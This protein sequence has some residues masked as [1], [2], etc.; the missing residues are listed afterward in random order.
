MKTRKIL[1]ALVA[2]MMVT[3]ILSVSAL[4]DV[5]MEP[6]YEEN[7]FY[8]EHLEELDYAY[9]TLIANSKDGYITIYDKPGGDTVKYRYENGTQIRTIATIEYE[10]EI[11]AI[12][13][14]FWDYS[15]DRPT[16]WFKRSEAA[17]R[18]SNY[19]YCAEHGGEW[20]YETEIVYEP[21]GGKLIAWTYPCS[22]EI[23]C[24][25]KIE[26]EP[27]LRGLYTDPDGRQWATLPGGYYE[28]Q[29][30]AWVCL[31]EPDSRDI[32]GTMRVEYDEELYPAKTPPTEKGTYTPVFLGVSAAVIAIVL[33]AIVYGKKKK[34]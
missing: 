25:V 24:E 9:E 26:A 10:N 14:D 27:F 20:D 23:L 17:K 11:W 34:S 19:E 5:L 13:C 6:D 32:P 33:V 22:G 28:C 15:D 18:Y 8:A 29:R 7:K 12:L 16:G 1:T 3:A 21:K 4:A 2:V 31:T 30:F